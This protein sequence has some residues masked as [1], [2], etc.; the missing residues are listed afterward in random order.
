MLPLTGIRILDLSRLLPGP[1]CTMLLADLGCEVIK[2]EEPHLGDY[3]RWV[4]PF[5]REESAL[6]CAVNRNKK[7]MT[8]NL[9]CRK[10]REVFYKMVSQSDIVVESFRPGILK[11]L[12]IHY[13]E[14]RKINPGIIYCSITAYGQHGPY[15]SRA[16]HDINIIGLGG[17]LGLTEGK[18]L[19]GIQIADMS[20]A[21][22]SCIAIQAALIMRGRTGQ[23]Q[24]I[25]ISMLDSVVSLLAVHASEYFAMDT[26]SD[27]E[28]VSLSGGLACYNVYRTQDGKFITLGAVEPKFWE[29]FCELIGS[30]ELKEKQFSKDQE[31]LKTCIGD[32]IRQKTQK[33]WVEI[34]TDV[35]TPVNSMGDVLKDPQVLSRNLISE[36]HHPTAGTILQVA[37]PMKFSFELHEMR[38]HPPLFGEHTVSLLEKLG[39]SQ[40]EIADMKGAG[41]I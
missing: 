5:I 20:S 32:I 29:Q 34:L 28:M 21:L 38:T 23:G 15:K 30:P 26:S 13:E 1:Y 10:G 27:Q 12:E 3:M 8:L 41:T 6:F 24:H 2:I 35:C 37:N 11:T 40:K 7:S 4:P 18:V 17:V 25:D 19:P 39:Y 31:L 33:E 36:L 22:M 9:K 14:A 16:A